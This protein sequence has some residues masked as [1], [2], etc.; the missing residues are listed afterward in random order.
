MAEMNGTFREIR[1]FV[2]DHREG[3]NHDEWVGF[4]RHLDQDGHDVSD[5]DRI[6]LALE[7]ERLRQTLKTAGVK[8]LG[9]KRIESVAA[10]FGSLYELRQADENQIA[11]KT[12]LPHKIAQELASSL[13]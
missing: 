12:G 6:G 2:Q 11:Q 9:P 8:G 13:R 10:E 3:W 7:Q 4:I 1:A 5:P